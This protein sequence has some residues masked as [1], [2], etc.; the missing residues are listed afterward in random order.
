M[1][2]TP[3]AE[4]AV[5]GVLVL[6]DEYGQG[7][8]TLA[9][10]CRRRGLPREYLTKIFASLSRSGLITPIRGKG[11]GYVLAR[12]P[13]S[14]SLLEVIEAVEGPIALNFCQQDPPQCQQDHCPVRP[15]WTD[16]QEYI[17]TKLGAHSLADLAQG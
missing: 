6:A 9:E 10:V 2:L 7:P 11:G 1:K 5:R 3:A 16:I 4:L 17:R 15:I 12:S 8:T 14:I 13:G